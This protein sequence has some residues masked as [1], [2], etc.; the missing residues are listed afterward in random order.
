MH[1]QSCSTCPMM[2][3]YLPMVPILFFLKLNPSQSNRYRSSTQHNPVAINFCGDM[4][5]SYSGKF[6]RGPN[7]RDFHTPTTKTQK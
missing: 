6:L 2:M 7:F 5:I 4:P 3:G 1:V